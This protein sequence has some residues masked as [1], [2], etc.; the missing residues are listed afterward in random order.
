MHYCEGCAGFN[1]HIDAA[2]L[3]K[4]VSC[5]GEGL[6]GITVCHEVTTVDVCGVESGHTTHDYGFNNLMHV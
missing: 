2:V 6:Y 4:F 1:R 5:I 3:T